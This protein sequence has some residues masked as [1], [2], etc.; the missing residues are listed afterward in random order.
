MIEMQSSIPIQFLG[1][2]ISLYLDTCD[3]VTHKYGLEMTGSIVL[4]PYFV[5]N[6]RKIRTDYFQLES[7]VTTFLIYER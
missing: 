2:F 4:V 3:F 1:N 6:V 5:I 7:K